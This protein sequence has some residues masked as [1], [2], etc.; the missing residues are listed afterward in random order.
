VNFLPAADIK[1]I[2][3]ADWLSHGRHRKP[4][5][6]RLYNYL[7]PFGNDMEIH[8]V[9]CKTRKDRT[10]AIKEV[11]IS[12]VDDPWIHVKDVAIMTMAGYVVDWAPE[13][14]GYAK[15]WCYGGRWESEAYGRRCRWKIN[16][17]V[18]NPEVLQKHPRFKY[19][20]WTPE[21]GGILDYLKAYIHH[22][23][24]ELLAKAGVGEFGNKIGFVR[25]IEKDKGFMRFFM[26]N[27]LEIRKRSH[28]VDVIRMAYKAGITMNEAAR[29]I[30]ARRSFKGQ[31]L[32]TC[33]DAVRALTYIGHN[34]KWEYCQYLKNCATLGMDLTDTKVTFP[35]QFKQRR[36][37]VNDRIAE[38]ERQKDKAKV[39]E[40]DVQIAAVAK[41]FVKFEKSRGVLSITLARKVSDLNREG[42]R[43]HNCLGD[44]HYAA[45]IARGE[46]LIA[47][48]R[49]SRKPGAA[50]AAV[51]YSPD[52]KKILQCYAA[53]NGK[54]PKPVL[55]FV[56]KVFLKRR[57]A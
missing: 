4:N 52:Q 18:L 50:L 35:K 5:H 54:P 36:T 48:V 44:G 38:I 15:Q 32:P 11:I 24:I 3:C 31:G 45:K 6:T 55:V 1:R 51:E 27:L 28:S 20:C 57:A 17:D 49:H 7:M 37:I 42:K 12:S 39:R 16:R 8:T 46:T 21:C 33:V 29:R 47:F 40:L 43:L 13:G 14:L 23:R 26:D 53:N 2:E 25:Q 10:L 19:C 30:D 34:S 56:N 41:R 22:P 9:A